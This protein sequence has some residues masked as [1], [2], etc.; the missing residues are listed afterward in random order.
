M[1]SKIFFNKVMNI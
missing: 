1:S